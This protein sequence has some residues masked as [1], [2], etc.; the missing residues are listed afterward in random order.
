MERSTKQFC[1]KKQ[2]HVRERSTDM[3]RK[4]FPQNHVGE[5]MQLHQATKTHGSQVPKDQG[6]S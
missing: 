4:A 1:G 6:Q 5:A 3:T 2:N